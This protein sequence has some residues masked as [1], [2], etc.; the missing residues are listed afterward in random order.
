[1][2]LN[3]DFSTAPL[4]KPEN[5]QECCLRDR[6]LGMLDSKVTC[7]FSFIKLAYL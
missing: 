7:L 5:L 3:K 1:M 4:G 6:E 2:S